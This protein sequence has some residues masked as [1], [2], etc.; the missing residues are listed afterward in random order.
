MKKT[1]VLLP[2]DGI[3]PE[4]SARR[5]T[6]LRETAHEFNHDSNSVNFRSVVPALMHPAHRSPTKRST[7]PKGDAVFLE[8]SATKW[9]RCR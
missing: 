7:L 2:G 5:G 9:I 1:I 4:V 3:G 8:R 6:I